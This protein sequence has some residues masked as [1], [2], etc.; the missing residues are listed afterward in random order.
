MLLLL[1]EG[2]KC[3]HAM[4]LLW[5]PHSTATSAAHPLVVE[6]HPGT[7][8]TVQLP[9]LRL[10]LPVHQQAACGVRC[11]ESSLA[12]RLQIDCLLARGCM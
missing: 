11:I 6:C 3:L 12:G 4:P 8:S 7:I 1:L 9:Q 5:N 10:Q 2:D